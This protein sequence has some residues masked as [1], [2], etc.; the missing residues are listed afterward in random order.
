MDIPNLE[1]RLGRIEAVLT[2]VADGD[3]D[4][5]IDLGQS[6]DALGSLEMGLNFMLLDLKAMENANREKE[7]QLLS[8]TAELEEKLITIAEQAEAIRELSTPVMEIW[9]GILVLPVVGIVDTKRSLDIMNNLLAAIVSHEAKCVLIDIT[10][11]EVVDTRTADYL[12]KISRAANLLGT[13]CLLTGLSPAVAQTLVEIG[14]S[15]A[16]LRTLR[17][18]KDGLMDGLRYLE[19]R[20][21][22]ALKE[23]ALK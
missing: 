19:E 8:Q 10:G 12:L 23:G 14:V 20:R 6:E 1:A 2:K 3:F 21:S 22:V 11:V 4:Q 17:N 13:R 16:E 7:Q 18:L 9:E 15:L 5:K